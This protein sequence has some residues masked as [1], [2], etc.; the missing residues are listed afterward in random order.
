MS[1]KRNILLF[2]ISFLFL[3]KTTF[4]AEE[5]DTQ[6]DWLH[7][8]DCKI[9]DK[10]GNEVWLTGVNW[11]G[12]NVGSQIFDGVWSRNMHEMLTEIA[13]HG[14]NLLRVPVSTQI[15]IQWKNG[16]P[17]PTTPK[18]NAWTN[19]ELCDEGKKVWDSFRLWT[20]AMTWCKELGIKIMIDVHSAESLSNGHIYNMWYSGKYTTEDWYEALEW[21]ADYYK[22]DDTII[23]IDLKNEPHGK[24][25]EP[26]F[27]KWDDSTDKNN[28]KYAAE[29][30]AM[31]I[32]NKNPN[33]LIMIEGI[34]IYP[35]EDKDWT[36]PP[37]E[38]VTYTSNFY[39][40]WW[41]GNFRGAK[42]Y[43][44]DLGKYQSQLVYS[45]H[46]YGPLVWVQ[47]WFE[48]DF[49]SESIM[50]EYWYDSWF[51]LL[52]EKVAPLLIGEWS[53]FM[54]GGPN[55][56]WME[57]IRD[58]MIENHIHHTFWCFNENSGDTGG[59]V[60][61]N[62]GKWDEEKYALVKPALWQDEKGKFISLDHKRPVGANGI[63]LGEY[64]GK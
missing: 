34:E 43:P 45:P 17:D 25:D 9:V 29:T 62:F 22:N 16:D 19:E 28:W 15:L 35:K 47:P 30:C 42:E 63:S 7:V 12:F 2:L 32:L 61:D 31:K 54:D 44:I 46:D 33:L 56:K 53:G 5:D 37:I 58:L 3:F 40:A 18:V 10:N 50:E 1:N 24:S 4:C 27:A 51:S 26:N 21:V 55:E 52:E 60:Y 11:F 39:N 36:Y 64:Y 57:L 14:F 13:D 59:L 23:A 6:D 38:W 48:D 20:Q 8:E 41:G 49:S